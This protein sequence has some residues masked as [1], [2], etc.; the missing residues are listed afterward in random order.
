MNI[1]KKQQLTDTENNL[2][3]TVG[4]GKREGQIGVEG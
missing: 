4:R 2:V 3:L 1:T